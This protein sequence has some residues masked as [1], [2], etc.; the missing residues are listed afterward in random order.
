MIKRWLDRDSTPPIASI[1][2]TNNSI[3]YDG[4]TSVNW[5]ASDNEKLAKVNLTI[6]N[7][8]WKEIYA[9][10]LSSGSLNLNA[11]D[12]YYA[13]N[14]TITLEAIDASNNKKIVQDIFEVKRWVPKA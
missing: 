5:N 4:K 13:G 14:Y 9:S 3:L 11:Q 12:L 1:S 8:K 2:I 7:P 10:N 6:K